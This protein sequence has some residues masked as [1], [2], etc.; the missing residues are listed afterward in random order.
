MNFD[1]KDIVPLSIITV[2]ILLPVVVAIE[3]GGLRQVL[4]GLRGAGIAILWFIVLVMSFGWLTRIRQNKREQQLISERGRQTVGDFVLLFQP[5]SE[6]RIAALLYPRIQSL[7]VTQQP[8]R[9]DDI[10]VGAPLNLDAEDLMDEVDEICNEC[11]I[12]S[13]NELETA[14]EKRVTVADSSWRSGP[15]R[16]R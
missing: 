12:Q 8:L 1:R 3:Y 13:R 14:L 2:A 7:T 16:P 6:R 11:D 9:G 5:G 15:G 10:M 4:V